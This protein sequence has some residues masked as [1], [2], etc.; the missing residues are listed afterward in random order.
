MKNIISILLL[1]L[2]LNMS[3]GQQ[4][5]A[6]IAHS[7]DFKINNLFTFGATEADM[8]NALGPY[9]GMGGGKTP[10]LIEYETINASFWP[11]KYSGQAKFLF[12]E[13]EDFLAAFELTGSAIHMN[14]KGTVFKVGDNINVLAS[15]FPI[16]Y[17]NMYSNGTV[18]M[19]WLGFMDEAGQLRPTEAAVSFE[20]DANNIITKIKSHVD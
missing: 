13:N 8:V 12:K 17:A 10:A 1:I 2:S 9:Q 18:M 7:K 15:L 6:D 3:Y 5:P 19:V 16:S 11:K 4:H 20:C 14:Y